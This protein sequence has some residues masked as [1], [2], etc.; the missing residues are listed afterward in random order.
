M[1]ATIAYFVVSHFLSR[2]MEDLGVR[3]SLVRKLLAFVSAATS[4][5]S[6]AGLVD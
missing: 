2:T 6:L 3:K 4:A 5:Y 1:L